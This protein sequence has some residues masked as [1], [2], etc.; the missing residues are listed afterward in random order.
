MFFFSLYQDEGIDDL[1]ERV[2]GLT[3]ELSVLTAKDGE[4][5]KANEKRFHLGKFKF[6]SH[7][8]F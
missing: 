5:S 7:K 2:A 6:Y 4:D 3:F 1:F 8:P